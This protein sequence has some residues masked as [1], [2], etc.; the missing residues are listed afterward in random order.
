[1]INKS[2]LFKMA[3]SGFR[4]QVRKGKSASFSK[5]LKW[6]WS[7]L[8]AESQSIKIIPSRETQK[9]VAVS[10]VAACVYTDQA[11]KRL[12]WIPKSIMKGS[13]VPAWFWDKK[14]KELKNSFSYSASQSLEI[15]MDQ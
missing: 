5:S 9:A 10:V 3:W 8:K 15:S 2:K 7:V 1:M 13:A 14:V 11:V 6:A 12:I 4:T